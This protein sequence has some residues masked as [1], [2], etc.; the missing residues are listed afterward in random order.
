MHAF[1]AL[2]VEFD[3]VFAQPRRQV[4]DDGVLLS[5][6]DGNPGVLYHFW[7]LTY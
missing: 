7:R 1:G 2:P 5:P 4:D 3:A 6:A